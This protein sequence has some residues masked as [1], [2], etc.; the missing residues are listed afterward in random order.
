MRFGLAL[1]NFRPFGTRD[2]LVE[3]AQEAEGLGYHSIWST[4]VIVLTRDAE[5]DR[6]SHCLEALT[7]ATYLAALTTRIQLGISVLVLPQRSPLVVAKEVATLDYLSGG[8]VVLGVGAGYH[9][10]QFRWLGADFRHRGARLDEYIL[11]MKE[12][13]T[14]PEPRFQGEYVAF[15][16]VVFSPR[17][18]Q[19]SGPAI[20]VGGS[21]PAVLRR[22]ARLAD[23]W[24]P[25]SLTPAQYASGMKEIRAL[26]HTSIRNVHWTKT[27]T[28]P[29]VLLALMFVAICVAML[30]Q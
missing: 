18:V 25:T 8:R 29:T 2:A 1:P 30:W 9:E 17:P 3:I 24:H 20:V 28:M 15:S 11:A 27:L 12:L 13:W 19:P 16:D 5:D 26:L 6:F 23:G 14:A 7:I 21:S 4:D 10:M 22:V